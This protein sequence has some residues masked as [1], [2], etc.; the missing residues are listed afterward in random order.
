MRQEI[1]KRQTLSRYV[2]SVTPLL[3]PEELRETKRRVE[4][5]AQQEGP[6]LHRR[7]V[8][9]DRKT[10]QEHPEESWLERWWLEKAYLVWRDPIAIN[11]N[12]FIIVDEHPVALQGGVVEQHVR[13]AAFLHNMACSYMMIRKYVAAA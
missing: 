1:T 10:Q 5:F 2:R 4:A 8:E 11:V 6:E 3:S 13:A 7:L 9:H 12:W